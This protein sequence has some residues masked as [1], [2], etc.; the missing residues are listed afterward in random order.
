MSRPG[1]VKFLFISIVAVSILRPYFSPDALVTLQTAGK[2]TRHDL[3]LRNNLSLWFQ[4][5]LDC[6]D[7]PTVSGSSCLLT[8]SIVMVAC[9]SWLG[10]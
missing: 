3:V 2:H 8:V 10:C 6:L 5:L 1:Y 7:L 9:Y 4:R